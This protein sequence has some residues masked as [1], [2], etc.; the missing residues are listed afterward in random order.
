MSRKTPR[1]NRNDQADQDEA[2]EVGTAHAQA[3]AARTPSEL[4]RMD[5]AIHT[6]IAFLE[7][8]LSRDSSRP[9]DRSPD[10][11]LEEEDTG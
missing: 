10:S 3:K 7:E 8:Q 5:K 2:Q 6:L 4:L 9:E 11:S 1:R